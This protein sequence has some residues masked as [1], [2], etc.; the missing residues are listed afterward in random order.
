M[1]GCQLRFNHEFVSC[2]TCGEQ[3]R[4]IVRGWHEAYGHPNRWT[5]MT[6]FRGVRIHFDSPN[7]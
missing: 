5:H 3:F 4:A 1:H 2:H 6:F 7:P